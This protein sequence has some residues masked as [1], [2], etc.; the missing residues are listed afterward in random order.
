MKYTPTTINQAQLDILNAPYL[1][2]EWAVYMSHVAAV[3]IAD[4]DLTA[5]SA[6]VLT[7]NGATAL[8]SGGTDLQVACKN[9]LRSTVNT[10]ITIACTDADD[11]A[12]NLVATFAPPAWA[13]NQSKNFQRGYAVDGVP[14]VLNKTFKT[15]T[16]LT[17]VVGGAANCGFTI[18]QLPAQ[19]DYTLIGC[20]SDVEWNDKARTAKGID[21]GMETDAFVKQGKTLPG[22]LKIGHK[23]KGFADGIAR[24]GGHKATVML[25]G[26]KDGVVTADRVVFTQFIIAPKMRMPEGEGEAMA[27]GDGKF[28]EALYF[29]A[30]YTP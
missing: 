6:G 11:A 18:W 20:V 22:E 9:P 23:M 7:D 21:C 25:V 16:S 10:V 8:P 13:A 3:P 17:S 15:I 19:A 12:V 4:I 29:V 28:V 30:G 5:A 1:G 26:I 24:F 14:S 27:E 2:G